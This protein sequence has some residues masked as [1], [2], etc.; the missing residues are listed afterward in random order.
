MAKSE[1]KSTRSRLDM[2]RELRQGK[3][4]AREQAALEAEAKEKEND[5]VLPADLQEYLDEYAAV[6]A[7]GMNETDYYA[8]QRRK[9]QEAIENELRLYMDK[10][11]INPNSPQGQQFANMYMKY[12][13][14]NSEDWQYANNMYNQAYTNQRAQD[15]KNQTLKE[16]Q[17]VK[18]FSNAMQQIDPVT[19]M[20]L[21]DMTM[22][23]ALADAQAAAQRTGN[24]FQQKKSDWDD[25]KQQAQYWK[26]QG[27]KEWANPD[28]WPQQNG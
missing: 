28:Y 18:D 8:Q 2:Y 16:Q 26:E 6:A 10:K 13:L 14:D 7:S 12:A 21:S 22:Q 25:Y 3:L 17:R 11:G 24:W 27:V 23:S 19:G 9:A 4:S 20:P 1:K 5:G 15:L